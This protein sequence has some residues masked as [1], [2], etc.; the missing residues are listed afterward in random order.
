MVDSEDRVKI[1]V[2]VSKQNVTWLDANYNNRSAYINDLLTEAREGD[3]QVK[4]AIREYQIQQLEEEVAGM[5]S[6]LESKTDRLENLKAQ[7]ESE[8]E[9]RERILEDAKEALDGANL[10]PDNP[11]VKNWAEKLDMMPEE[12]IEELDE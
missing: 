9:K 10:V 6:R 7:Q 1:S 11:A 2:S 3:G 5:E 12:L 8:A 4:A